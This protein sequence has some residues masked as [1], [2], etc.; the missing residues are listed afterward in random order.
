MMDNTLLGQPLNRVDG[1]LKVTGRAVYA[2]EHQ[3]PNAVYAVMVMS[4]IPK[5]TITAMNTRTA[6]QVPGVQL[7]MTHRNSPKF[8]QL[9]HQ[10]IGGPGGRVVQCLQDNLVRY[11]NQ[12]IA[13]V[14]AETLEAALEGAHLVEVRYAVEPH[15]I[16]LESR[17]SQAYALKHS[18]DAE[19]HRGDVSAALATSAIRI[20]HVYRTPFEVHNPMEPHATIAVWDKPD[21]LTLYDA[22]QG[23]FTDRGRVASLLGLPPD[24]VRVVSPFLG[25][26]FG[27]KGPV[28]SHVILAAMAAKEVNRPVKLS[29]TRPQMFGMIG[30]RSETRQAIAAGANHDGTMM[31]LRNDTVTHTST[32]DEFVEGASRPAR[33]LY[34]SPNNS[35]SQKLVESDIGTP[36][37]MR[38]PGEAPGTYGLEAAIDELAYAVKMDPLEFRLKN[39]AETD[40]EENK[41]WSSKSL[42]Q[43]YQLGAERFGWAKRSHEPRSMRDGNILVGWGMATSVYPTR[44]SAAHASARLNADGTFSV[45]AGTQDLGTGT[46]TIMTQVAADSFGVPATRVKFRLGDT[47]LPET[48]V[49]GGSQTAA[50]TGSAVYLA[51][52]ALREKLIQMASADPQSPLAGLGAQQIIFEN[53][54]LSSRTDPSKGETF[55]AL[56]ARSGQSY[57]EAPA[58][59]TPGPEKDRYSMYA[60]GAQFAEVRVDPDLGLVTVSRMLG[61]FA[62]GKILNAKTA[63]SQL[64]GGMIWGIG[65]AL[66]EEALTDKRLGRWV[67]NNLAEYHVPA[68]ADVRRIEA[69]WV[70]E[71]DDHVNPIGVKGIGEIGITGAAAAVA[72][73]VFHATGKRVR[74]LPITLDKLIA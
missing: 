19:K 30:F 54:R 68:N 24:S 35:T 47:I 72:N 15:R 66:Y 37:Y 10:S 2:Y 23:V 1:P 38:A 20:D 45:D 5:G 27:S 3:L 70:D 42:R 65:M 22:T 34:S 11:A 44:R 7:V 59:A 17:L 52:Q 8:P 49:S 31:A 13:M 46:Y 55:Q 51:A 26:G 18:K 69:I 40:P 64:I 53:G 57:V 28:W 43:C 36:S 67:N 56:I 21:H 29:L 14:V 25:G 32:F 12:P 6:E 73:A 63:R 60:F 48:P 4:T 50:S 33:M 74:D 16:D 39:Y 58:D 61:C 9:A 62:A 41:P 71:R